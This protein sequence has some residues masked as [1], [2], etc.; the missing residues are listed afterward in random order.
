MSDT[1]SSA[2]TDR[3]ALITEL[4]KGAVDLHCHSGPSVMPRGIDHIEA[5]KE[6]AEAGMKAVLVK[7]HFYSATP[8]TELL[9]RQFGHLGV[10]M[11]SGVP[12][13]NTTGDFNP[14]AVD[15]GIKL[16]A[17]LVWMP[18]F[19]SANHIRHHHGDDHFDTKFPQTVQ[20]VLAPRPLTVLDDAGAVKDE[21]KVILDMIAAYD[22]VLSGGHLHVTEI[23]KL[24]EVAKAHGVK[25]LLVNHPTF[26]VDATLEDVA[27]LAGMGAYIEH[28]VCMWAPGSCFL[29]YE[30]E[31]LDQLI[32]AA[33]VDRT[34][35][36]SDLGQEGNP[37]PVVGFRSVIGICLDLG[38]SPEDVRKMIATNPCDLAGIV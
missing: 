33:G 9:N 38:Y 34:I 17:R 3:E 7:D 27:T 13:N 6:A 21:V 1:E 29:F 15:H 25:R 24:F 36:G 4:L 19:S 2:A 37:S 5:M 23:L 12:L 14:H 32:K 35:L 8:V 30:P 28:S 18:T 31:F 26:V 10:Q 11:L 16:G 20:D 22:L